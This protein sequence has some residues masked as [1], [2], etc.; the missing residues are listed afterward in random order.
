MPDITIR[1]Q[2]LKSRQFVTGL[3]R[4]CQWNL[5]LPERS[6]VLHGVGGGRNF[7]VTRL[8]FSVFLLT[9][10]FKPLPAANWAGTES[11]NLV[12]SANWEPG[13]PQPNSDLFFDQAAEA[14]TVYFDFASGARFR[15][16]DI[17]FLSDSNHDAESYLL[18]G[19]GTRE[20]FV[21]NIFNQTNTVHRFDL[22]VR[23]GNFGTVATEGVLEFGG[24]IDTHTGNNRM[25]FGGMGQVVVT[26]TATIDSSTELT[27][28]DQVT[29]AVEGSFQFNSLR[30]SEGRTVVDLT[31]SG[32]LLL[33]SLSVAEG[34]FLEIVNWN[35][36]TEIRVQNEVDSDSLA[37]VRVNGRAAVWN[38]IASEAVT[39]V[40]EPSGYALIAGLLIGGTLIIKIRLK[41]QTS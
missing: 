19:D 12:S 32:S 31:D 9:T 21:R 36:K 7:F 22:D 37:N 29:F 27:L 11:D 24:N 34:S 20:L 15:F 33:D 39:P 6:A 1:I 18:T 26:G 14:K 30:V 16:G 2:P 40:P 8:L 4:W 35:E 3:A 17:V 38:T 13:P 25:T 23:F 28:T 10:F 5:R 41:R